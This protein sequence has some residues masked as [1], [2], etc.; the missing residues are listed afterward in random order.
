MKSLATFS[1]RVLTF[2]FRFFRSC[3]VSFQM[4]GQSNADSPT[5]K[6]V[7]GYPHLW[8]TLCVSEVDAFAG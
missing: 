8:I 5:V 1:T 6:R 7:P 2:G 4:C 3:E